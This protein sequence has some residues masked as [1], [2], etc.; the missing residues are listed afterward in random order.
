MFR[1]MLPQAKGH[2]EPPE[3]GKGKKDHSLEPSGRAAD[4]LTLDFWPPERGENK[5]LWFRA[6]W[7]AAT[8][9]SSPRK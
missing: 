2:Q 4:T 9:H 6:T 8:D 3:A 1:V 7:F 5:F